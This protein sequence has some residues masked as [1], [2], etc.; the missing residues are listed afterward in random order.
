MIGKVEY[1]RVRDQ[2]VDR[3]RSGLI[4]GEYGPGG[5]LIERDLVDRLQTG[6]GPIRD[7]LLELTKE[8]LLVAKPNCGVRVAPPVPAE[9]AAL[10][11]G[12]RRQIETHALGQ[13]FHAI[14]DEAMAGWRRHLREF[15]HCCKAGEMTAVVHEDMA[16]HRS[17]VQLPG[18]GSLI[19]AW[20]PVISRMVL[21]YSRHH[22]LL[23]SFEEHRAIV[24]AIEAGD[25]EAA[26]R[27]LAANIR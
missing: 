8:G 1:R 14:T 5:R 26:I 3:L 23:E 22:D 12:L 4:S 17:I 27:A 21:P 10:M 7:A 16:F 6:R 18:Q 2:V 15:E 25:R 11:A 24:A 20:L 9:T 19:P 13:S